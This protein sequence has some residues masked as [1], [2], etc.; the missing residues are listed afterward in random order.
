MAEKVTTKTAEK[1]GSVKDSDRSSPSKKSN[2]LQASYES[3]G[4]HNN[5]DQENG[6]KDVDAYA[7]DGKDDTDRAKLPGELLL[8]ASQ[9]SQGSLN[10][11]KADVEDSDD[12]EKN[13][14]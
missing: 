14:I 8:A 7:Y 3:H 1:T 9:D 11:D 5:Q 2:Q 10:Q 12:E 4:S 6:D 13:R